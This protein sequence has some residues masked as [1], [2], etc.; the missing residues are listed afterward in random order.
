MQT[1]PVQL[2]YTKL[3]ENRFAPPYWQVMVQEV[4]YTD[5]GRAYLK[6]VTILEHKSK[7]RLVKAVHLDGYT[8]RAVDKLPLVDLQPALF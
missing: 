4:A 5:K 3:Q 8:A 1:T 2:T 7:A 6:V